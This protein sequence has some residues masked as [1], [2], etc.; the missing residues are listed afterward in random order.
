MKTAKRAPIGLAL[1]LFFCFVFA[2][3]AQPRPESVE[4]ARTVPI[5]DVH[6]HNYETTAGSFKDLMDRNNV[7]WAGAVGHLNDD[8]RAKLKDRYIAAIGQKEFDTILRQGRSFIDP[9]QWI[10]NTLF[11][12]A[13]AGFK[14][15]SLKGFGELHTDN[16][17][18]SPRPDYKRHFRLDSPV[19][20]KVFELANRYQAFIQIHSGMDETFKE[21]LLRLSNEFPQATIILSHCLPKAR[22]ADIRNLFQQRKNI[23]CELSGGGPVHASMSNKLG[24]GKFYTSNGLK[25]GWKDLIEEFPNQVMLGS[26]TCFGLEKRYDEIIQEQ[27]EQVLAYLTPATLEQV[28]YKN[29][30]RVLRL[31]E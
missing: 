19:M 2:C 7:R 4:L 26:D 17:D 30:V 8:M 21:D 1:C 22:P 31:K 24:D 13:E 11:K 28:A 20:R 5:A 3:R 9:D 18:S 10:F 23:M 15:G 16:E 6:L 27:R 29:A 25:S 12:D 14:D